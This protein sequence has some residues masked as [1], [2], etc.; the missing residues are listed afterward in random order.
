MKCNAKFPYR[1]LLPAIF[2]VALGT[3]CHETLPDYAAPGNVLSVALLSYEQLN[4]HVAPPTHPLVHLV[5]QCRNE[6]DEVFWDSVGVSGTMRIWWKRKPSRFT[7]IALS[8]KNFT[9]RSLVN[10]GKLL[11]VP[12]QQ[13]TLDAYWNLVGDNGLNMIDEMDWTNPTQKYCAANVY[14]APPEIFVVEVSLKI[15]NRLG[16]V[17]APDAQI[18]IIGRSCA[19]PGYPPC[20]F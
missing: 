14:C 20:N 4:D 18:T 5:V 3:G 7:T 19:V 10:N 13:F 1:L 6:H 17:T 12:G 16:V 11:L 9:E 8:E 15:Y 2:L